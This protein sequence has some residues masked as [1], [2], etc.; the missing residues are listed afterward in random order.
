M[1]KRIVPQRIVTTGAER[2]YLKNIKAVKRAKKINKALTSK[3][4]LGAKIKEPK[5]CKVYI[6]D[7]RKYIYSDEEKKEYS[8]YKKH[9]VSIKYK[10]KTYCLILN[11]RC[12][13]VYGI[14]DRSLCVDGYVDDKNR[15]IINFTKD[16]EIILDEKGT[17]YL[18][19][20]EEITTVDQRGYQHFS[21]NFVGKKVNIV[22]I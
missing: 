17:I 16:S 13:N 20:V 1:N 22:D 15:G 3:V 14:K 5:S 7:N 18:D 6:I 10:P 2:R 4:A 8:F 19:D 21:I 9:L 12:P 11:K